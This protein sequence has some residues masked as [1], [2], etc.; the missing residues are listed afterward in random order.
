MTRDLTRIGTLLV[1]GL[2]VAQVD[3]LDLRAALNKLLCLSN[4]GDTDD[5]LVLVGHARVD[6]FDCMLHI[7]D[8]E[9]AAAGLPMLSC[10]L[11]TGSLADLIAHAEDAVGA[12]ALNPGNCD[13]AMKQAMV[14]AK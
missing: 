2:G 3:R 12:K 11:H 1:L 5:H 10:R 14:N 8:D 7:F 4:S 13:L 6:S 9:L